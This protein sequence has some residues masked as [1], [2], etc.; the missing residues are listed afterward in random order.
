M[1]KYTIFKTRWG[2]F[3]LAAAD[4]AVMRTCLPLSNHEK[5]K[6]RI[7]TSFLGQESSIEH[8]LSSVALAKEEASRIEFDKDL[9]KTL[10]N[11]IIAYFE[12][13][14]VDFRNVPV[15]LNELSV[16]TKRILTA[17][18][19]IQFGQTISYGRLAKI[20]GSPGSARAVGNAL[21]K[22]PL[23][24]IIPCHRVLCSNGSL[25]GF[26]APGGIN[27]KK[28]MLKLESF[29]RISTIT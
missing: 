11:Q 23:P 18:R 6:R 3:G 21:A 25:G 2:Y 13:V 9:F 1:I 24:L 29:H 27:L 5:V 19:Y 10:Q 12:V 22:N 28:R 15:V 4:N 14:R 8:R 26:S 7:L 20:A 16:F 17:C